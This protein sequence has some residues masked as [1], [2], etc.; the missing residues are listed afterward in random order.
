MAIYAHEMSK[1]D[2]FEQLFLERMRLIISM[3][4]QH[5]QCVCEQK[6]IYENELELYDVDSVSYH[7]EMHVFMQL[8][9]TKDLYL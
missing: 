1:D 6:R 9:T 7:R 8:T 2:I 5:A 3:A 4:V